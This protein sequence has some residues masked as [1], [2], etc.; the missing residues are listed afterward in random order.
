VRRAWPAQLQALLGAAHTVHNWGHVA[1]TMQRTTNCEEGTALNCSGRTCPKGR[2]GGGPLLPC[3]S[4]GPP[5]WVTQEFATATNRSAPLTH[6][7]IV[8]GTNDAKHTNWF[9][10]GNETQYTA[11]AAAMVATFQ[12]LPQKPK[13]YLATPPPLY[14][15]TYTM[16]QTLV[17]EIMPRILQKVAAQAGVEFLD[18]VTPL[19]G[20]P[21][22]S[23]PELFLPN[24]TNGGCDVLKA[25]KGDGCHPDD[26]GHKAIATV[27]AG[28][29]GL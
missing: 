3:R 16:N 19:G 18:L 28:V 1:A 14:H 6:V 4:N 9:Y 2:G 25:C 5:Y 10:L 24:A 20:W 7:V 8:L 23:M 21:A 15:A 17:G 26:L 11:D 13:I 22:L 27:V 29:L 12:A